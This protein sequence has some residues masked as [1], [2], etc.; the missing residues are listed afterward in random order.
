MSKLQGEAI[1][2]ARKAHHIWVEQCEAAKAVKA[3]FGLKAAFDYIVGEK[4]LNLAESLA[5]TIPTS[6]ESCRDSFPKY[7]DVHAR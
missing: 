6:R 7:A 1:N 4:L 3:R 2:G 5:S